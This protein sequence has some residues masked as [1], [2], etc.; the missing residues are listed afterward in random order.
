MNPSIGAP[1]LALPIIPAGRRIVF[2]NQMICFRERI[3]DWNEKRFQ[4]RLA[5]VKLADESR[6]GRET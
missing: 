1:D 6:Q 4:L 2:S 3:G 5:R